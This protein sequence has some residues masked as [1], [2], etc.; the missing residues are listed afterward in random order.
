MT[1]GCSGEQ[2]LQRARNLAPLITE[3]RLEIE[4]TRAIPAALV[5]ALQDADIFRMWYPSV[6]G[7]PELS[8]GEL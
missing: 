1:I 3:S 2:I 4:R 8:I 7:G 5:S 6:W